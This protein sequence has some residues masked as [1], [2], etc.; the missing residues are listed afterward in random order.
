[1]ATAGLSTLLGSVTFIV[2]RTLIYLLTETAPAG[3]HFDFV[4]LAIAVAIM[5]AL[6][7]GHHRRLLG[8]ERTDPVRAYEYSSTAA[9]MGTG[10]AA[11]TAL[12]SAVFGE[13]TIVGSTAANA[14]ASAATLLVAFAVWYRFW[15]RAQRAPRTIEAAGAPRRLY[16]LGTGVIMSLVGGGALIAALVFVFQ[17]LLGVESLSRAVLPMT[18]LFLS[19]GAAAWHLLRTYTADRGLIESKEVVTP[20][21]VTVICSHPGMLAARFPKE[22]RVRVIYRADEMGQVDEEMADQIVSAVDNT[23]S[24]VWVDQTGFQVA[25]AR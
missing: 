24:I 6:V 4:P 3:P 11:T 8:R 7:W 18:A 20:F 17:A 5:A 15:G 14:I 25:P 22:A 16:L 19:A 1:M 2:A 12:I 21:D 9:A 23:S 10:V 13:E